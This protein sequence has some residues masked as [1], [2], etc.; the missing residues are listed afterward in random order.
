MKN[1]QTVVDE[2]VGA[3]NELLEGIEEL[4]KDEKKDLDIYFDD[5]LKEFKP[6]LSIFDKLSSDE[7]T[8][9]NLTGAIKEHA[10]EEKWLEKLSKTFYD[11]E[12]IQ[13]LLQNPTPTE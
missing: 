12:I 10:K 1:T 4:T 2:I 8:L 7:K 13:D 11:Q 9:K 6:M 3:K 5:L